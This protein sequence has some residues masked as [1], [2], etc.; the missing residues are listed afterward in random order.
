[1]I[2]VTKDIQI[3]LSPPI[4][5]IMPEY[6]EPSVWPT[7]LAAALGAFLGVLGSFLIARSRDMHNYRRIEI[8]KLT[9]VN[10][11]CRQIFGI[12]SEI[13]DYLDRILS[14]K[15]DKIVIDFSKFRK[16]AINFDEVK[17]TIETLDVFTKENSLKNIKDLMNIQNRSF[18]ILNQFKL[19]NTKHLELMTIYD[20]CEYTIDLEK[21]I[22]RTT[23]KNEFKDDLLLIK[24]EIEDIFT[25]IN[26]NSNNISKDEQTIKNNINDF[27][28][29]YVKNGNFLRLD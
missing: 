18:T 28:R 7:L 16:F 23:I 3:S 22:R 20:K 25:I 15:E 12:N 19:L 14:F 5:A 29:I 13:R 17:F 26:R 9:A 8:T 4:H 2:D 11:N 6:I 27:I 21:R 1:M 10:N 24:Q